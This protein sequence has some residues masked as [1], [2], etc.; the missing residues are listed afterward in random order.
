VREAG[1]KRF[2]SWFSEADPVPRVKTLG[3]SECVEIRGFCHAVLCVFAPI[4]G[5]SGCAAHSPGV[6]KFVLLGMKM[7]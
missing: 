6:V 5:A 7:A 2:A 1:S 4:R 3:H